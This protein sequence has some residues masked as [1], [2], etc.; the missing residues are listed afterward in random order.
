M[1]KPTKW[2]V[3]PANIRIR[4]GIRSVW[5][6]S[7]LSAWRKHE[8]LSTHWAHSEDSDQTGQTGQMPRLICVF[9]MRTCPFVGLVIRWINCLQRDNLHDISSGKNKKIFQNVALM[10]DV[11]QNN[12]RQNGDTSSHILNNLSTENADGSGCL[13]FCRPPELIGIYA[14]K[15]IPFPIAS[16]GPYQNVL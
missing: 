1:T 15:T 12:R 3:R 16:F 10:E 7:S 8:S 5:S 9:A 2:H 6:E 4:L 13:K 14:K 11:K